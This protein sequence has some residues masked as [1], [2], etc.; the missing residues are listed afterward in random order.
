MKTTHHFVRPFRSAGL[1]AAAFVFLMPLAGC[2]QVP[3]PSTPDQAPATQ[4]PTMRLH[5]ETWVNGER[6]VVDTLIT[7]GEG[8]NGFFQFGDSLLGGMNGFN[9]SMPGF[10]MPGSPF[11]NQDIFADPFFNFDLGMPGD[12]QQLMERHQ[13][14]MDEMMKGMP[15]MMP[16]IP[17]PPPQKKKPYEEEIIDI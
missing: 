3:P 14:M 9:F 15:R 1:L 12:M 16:G 10:S 13:K 2:S 4:G 17:P 7:L 11:G 5:S 8:Q 6:K